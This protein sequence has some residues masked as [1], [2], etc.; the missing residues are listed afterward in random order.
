MCRAFSSERIVTESGT[1]SRKH[2]Y[3]MEGRQ[4]MAKSEKR[5][6]RMPATKFPNL[7]KKMQKGKTQAK[8]AKKK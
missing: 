5:T 1:Q 3:L 7:R 4:E 8:Q 2:R 6:A